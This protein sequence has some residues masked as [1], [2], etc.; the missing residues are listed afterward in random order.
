MLYDSVHADVS[1][2]RERNR[3]DIALAADAHGSADRRGRR[4]GGQGRIPAARMNG[5]LGQ[6]IIVAIIGGAHGIAEHVTCAT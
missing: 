1:G 2:N 3:P 5:V 4:V 6:Q